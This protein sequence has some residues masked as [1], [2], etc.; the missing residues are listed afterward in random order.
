[1]KKG[2]PFL[3]FLLL[4]L[5]VCTGCASQ[6]SN[7]TSSSIT[8]SSGPAITQHNLPNPIDAFEFVEILE[9]EG[10]GKVS[11]DQSLAPIDINSTIKVRIDRDRLISSFGQPLLSLSLEN[12][13]PQ[14]EA[15]LESLQLIKEY[16]VLSQQ[17]QSTYMATH[18]AEGKRL[19]GM[20]NEIKILTDKQKEQARMGMSILRNV[21]KYIAITQQIQFTGDP[22]F[23]QE[24]SKWMKEHNLEFNSVKDPILSK[25]IQDE[26]NRMNEIAQG[27]MD[28]L[29]QAA[30]KFKLRIRARLIREGGTPTPFHVP[31]YDNLETGDPRIVD[32]LSLKLDEEREK[33]LKK[34]VDFHAKVADSINGIRNEG[35]ELRKTLPEVFNSILADI[36]QLLDSI[37]PEQI[38]ES[39][40]RPTK[41]LENQLI[42]LEIQL[43]NSG[44]S[45]AELGKL[46]ELIEKIKTLR[47]KGENI[48][49]S[50]KGLNEIKAL[51]NA[52][53]GDILVN[54]TQ[55]AIKD[56]INMAKDISGFAASVKQVIKEIENIYA[57][58]GGNSLLKAKLGQVLLDGLQKSI[59][60]NFK[61]TIEI[62]EKHKDL[63][64]K[65]KEIAEILHKTAPDLIRLPE[66]I[67]DDSKIRDIP[68]DEIQDTELQLLRT[69]RRD[70]DLVEF[71][72]QLIK[73]DGSV[74]AE[75]S[76]LFRVT[77]FGLHS[78]VSGNVIFVNRLENPT[79]VEEV[80]FVAAPAV[81][82]TFRYRTREG[83][84]FA[85]VWNIFNP[86]M[87]LN[88]SL[89]NFQGSDAE[90][91]VGA[92][93]SLFGDIIQGGYGYN[94]QVDSKHGYFF[95]G[96]GLFEMIGAM[97]NN[98]FRLPEK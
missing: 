21:K 64:E 79:G 97:G 57:E 27:R 91:G 13:S 12:I 98:Q 62:L 8:P 50:L 51:P 67:K 19:P 35:K 36:R 28:R 63:I 70:R 60:E 48:V 94:L 38:E 59:N 1:M 55:R 3:A 40:V 53:P 69:S 85:K 92:T 93:L 29:L 46:K 82:Y 25:F 72:F 37:K 49:K 9:K 10:T 52:S 5:A 18:D 41:T 44:V 31:G 39:L 43:K 73:N 95:V 4:A 32:K 15:L 23:S 47:E 6:V 54:L 84:T 16:L 90:L 45:E 88:T 83:S 68:L 22:L 20:E 26:V 61:P 66:G 56:G 87:G 14:R 76:R 34:E 17:I 30:Q 7:I 80:N 86:G 77:K 2:Y 89:L 65:I 74:M 78:N 24:I 96:I 75:G 33:E 58:I 71:T 42:S 11:S 81:S